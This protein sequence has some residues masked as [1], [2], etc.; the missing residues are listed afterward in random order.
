[1]HLRDYLKSKN[2]SLAE[3]GRRIGVKTQSVHRYAQYGR[4]PDGKV[5]AKIFEVTGGVVTP[6]DFGPAPSSTEAA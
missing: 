2:L 4:V 5:M 6:S 3:F 1:M